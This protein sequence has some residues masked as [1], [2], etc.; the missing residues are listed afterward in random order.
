MFVKELTLIAAVLLTV[1]CDRDGGVIGTATLPHIRGKFIIEDDDRTAPLTSVQ[2][3]I[4]YVVGDYR[5]LIFR[6]SNAP[7]PALSLLERDNILV[8]YCGGRVEVVESSFAENG[9]ELGA[10]NRI[11]RL[12]PVTSPGLSANGRTICEAAASP[13]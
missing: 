12:Q 7:M 6:G 13:N 8:R 10:D 11:L 5:K 4:Y 3:S 1:G 9:A 2:H